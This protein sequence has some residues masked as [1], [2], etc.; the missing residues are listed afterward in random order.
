[1]RTVVKFNNVSDFLNARTWCYT[2][3]DRWD[4]EIH[5]SIHYYAIRF[6]NESD[7]VIVKLRF[8]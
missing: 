6:I 2:N 8:L 3:L 7:A 4:F 5:S 1:M